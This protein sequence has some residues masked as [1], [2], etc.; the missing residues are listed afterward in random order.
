M[1]AEID[2]LNRIIGANMRRLRLKRGLTLT[3]VGGFLSMTYQQIQKYEKG[4]NGISAAN[5]HRLATF[6]KCRVA[7]FFLRERGQRPCG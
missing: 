3:L 1:A 4:A 2:P 5:L 6:F 7:D